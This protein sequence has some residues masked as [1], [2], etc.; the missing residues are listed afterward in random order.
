MRTIETVKRSHAMSDET[1]SIKSAI[2]YVMNYFH[3]YGAVSR[4]IIVAVAPS[5]ETDIDGIDVRFMFAGDTQSSVF[6]VWVKDG[7]LYG[8]W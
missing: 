3:T 5:A 2:Q 1:L 7:K 4:L 8:E 6:T